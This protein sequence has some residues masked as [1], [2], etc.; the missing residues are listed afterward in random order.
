[1]QIKNE[2]IC[3]IKRKIML[4]FPILKY[5]KRTEMFTSLH[6]TITVIALKRLLVTKLG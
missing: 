5:R 1:M 2:F 3:T 4:T 6:K